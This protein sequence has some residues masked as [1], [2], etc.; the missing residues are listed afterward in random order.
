MLVIDSHSDPY[1]NPASTYPNAIANWTARSQMRDAPFSL[2]DTVGFQYPMNTGT[3]F[4]GRPAASTFD[5]GL[6]YYSGLEY[7]KR[8]PDPCAATQWYDMQWDSSAVVPARGFYSTKTRGG[9]GLT[10]A[11]GIRMM[12]FA[13]PAGLC[14]ASWYGFWYVPYS[15]AN[16]TG[17]PR[18]SGVDYGWH[19]QIVDQSADGTTATVKIWNTH[20]KGALMP[21][22]TTTNL[23]DTVTWN[24]GL[25]KND[26]NALNLF[27][28]VTL[29]SKVGYVNG[30]VTGGAVPLSDTCANVAAAVASGKPLAQLAARSPRATVA[31]GWTGYVDHN[32]SVNFGFGTTVNALTGVINQS[33][34]LYNMGASWANLPAPPVNILPVVRLFFPWMNR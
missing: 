2:K 9:A 25:P 11:T 19:V 3:W 31:V 6:G 16:N 14:Q 15:D 5:D 33:V 26:G 34:A 10:T 17:N 7:A 22:K 12:G 13:N 30:S 29:D 28:C 8:G 32:G 27:A 24:Y 18:D 20:Y 4:N 1:R 23:N 21:N